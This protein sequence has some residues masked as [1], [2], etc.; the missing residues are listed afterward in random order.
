MPDA[1]SHCRSESDRARDLRRAAE[2]REKIHDEIL[3]CERA[4]GHVEELTDQ[5]M[6]HIRAALGECHAPAPAASDEDAATQSAAGIVRLAIEGYVLHDKAAATRA[7]VGCLERAG[8]LSQRRPE[9][10]CETEL[11]AL[12]A[13]GRQLEIRRSKPGTIVLYTIA[14]MEDRLI[15]EIGH[16]QTLAAALAAAKEGASEDHSYG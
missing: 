9:G 1:G 8:L 15:Q 3:A 11:E 14:R 10:A 7:I 12:L 4:D 2:L 13:D 16:G 6:G 5:I